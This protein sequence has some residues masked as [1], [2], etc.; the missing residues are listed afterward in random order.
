MGKWIKNFSKEVQIAKTQ[1]KKG[2]TL[3]SFREMQIKTTRR[4]QL[5]MIRM[6]VIKN[7]KHN[8]DEDTRKRNPK[9]DDV[10]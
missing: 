4:K 8:T 3:L 1:V 9:P 10:H 6:A 2:S 7:A 5:T